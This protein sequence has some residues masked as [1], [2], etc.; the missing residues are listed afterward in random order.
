MALVPTPPWFY[1]RPD[2]TVIARGKPEPGW[3]GVLA[4]PPVAVGLA[5]VAVLLYGHGFLGTLQPRAAREVAPFVAPALGLVVGAVA[6]AVVRA[7]FLVRTS[8]YVITDARVYS[9]VGRLWT[10]VHFT[11]H[12]KVTDLWYGR[13]VLDRVFGTSTLVLMT[14]GGDVAIR[15][16][17]DALAV[18][19]HAEAARERFIAKLL[20]RVPAT[21]R[22]APRPVARATPD[23]A[24]SPAP[25]AALPPLTSA[26]AGARPD[27]VQQGDRVL[28]SGKPTLR[29]AAEGAIAPFLLFAA[30]AFSMVASTGGNFGPPP[31]LFVA[32]PVIAVVVVGVRLLALKRMEF[33]VTDRRV[34]VRH[35]IVGTVVAQLTYDK[36]TDIV[37][38]RD[39]P[40]RI[41]GYGSLTI[42]TAG[43]VGAPAKMIGLFD[44]I[45]VK[46]I[47]ESARARA[48]DGPEA[49]A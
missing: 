31:I 47:I 49:E 28:W 33:V 35:G 46:E 9:R 41:L 8:E 16:V 18:K 29:V 43:S 12:D 11:T 2:E 36:I 30:W 42:N 4:V 38:G 20:E 45:A 44:A 3:F 14:A 15:G 27:Y 21:A 39:I 10:R 7:W 25:A 37:Y 19:E 17:A 40:G 22:A 34:Y 13:N 26:P 23:V 32:V 1:L 48:V 24:A 5:L 6:A